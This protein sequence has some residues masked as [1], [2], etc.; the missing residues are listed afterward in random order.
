MTNNARCAALG[1]CLVVGGLATAEPA[2][3]DMLWNLKA[4]KQNP[5][6]AICMGIAGGANG[7]EV[8][9]GTKIIVWDCINGV[10]DQIWTRTADTYFGNFFGNLNVLIENRAL[11][12]GSPA[13]LTDIS[14]GTSTGD[15]GVQ[16]EIT[17]CSQ[18]SVSQQFVFHDMHENDP[19]GY[20]CYLLASDASGRVVGVANASANPVQRGMPVIMWDRNT[21]D[22]QVWCVH[23]NPPAIIVP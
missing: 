11:D 18:S 4:E 12:S 14:N 1:L 9:D 8:K 16:L 15:K 22:D 7:G 10:D 17:V 3:A 5:S 13:C 23:P 2:K 6:K 20:P 21:S 19:A